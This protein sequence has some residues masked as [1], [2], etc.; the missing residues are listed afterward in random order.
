MHSSFPFLCNQSELDWREIKSRLA[1]WVQTAELVC[2]ESRSIEGVKLD[3]PL[4]TIV[5]VCSTL[6]HSTLLATWQWNSLKSNLYVHIYSYDWIDKRLMK[7]PSKGVS[8]VLRT[9]WNGRNLLNFLQGGGG[10]PIR[11]MLYI[12]TGHF[13]PAEHRWACHLYHLF[14]LLLFL[15]ERSFLAN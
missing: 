5:S 14:H 1:D 9:F 11:I 6:I 12:W 4:K 15:Q 3:L 10:W 8:K 7:L 13:L 2:K